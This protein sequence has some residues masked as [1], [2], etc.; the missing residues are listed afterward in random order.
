[1][2]PFIY[3]SY[4]LDLLHCQSSY[5]AQHIYLLYILH[6]FHP[7]N[8]Y[9]PSPTHTHHVHSMCQWHRVVEEVYVLSVTWRDADD[10]DQYYMCVRVLHVG[11]SS[12][13][14]FHQLLHP[15]SL[16]LMY[17]PL[18]GCLECYIH[19]LFS[20]FFLSFYFFLYSRNRFIGIVRERERVENEWNWRYPF[21]H[22]FSTLPSVFFILFYEE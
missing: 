13:R 11:C 19:S 1:M 3:L 18:A 15:P 12:E 2:E 22:S 16:L 6:P 17:L 9:I 20:I 7:F 21:I 14:T 5:Y 4:M 10:D 8:Q